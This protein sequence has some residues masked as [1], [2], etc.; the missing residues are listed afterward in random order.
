MATPEELQAAHDLIWQ[1]N[2]DELHKQVEA[3]MVRWEKQLLADIRKH[4]AASFGGWGWYVLPE[5]LP[6][7][8]VESMLKRSVL[9]EGR[10]AWVVGINGEVEDNGAQTGRI[11]QRGQRF[12]DAP[13]APDY[14]V[15]AQEQEQVNA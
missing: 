14:Q 3:N 10:I 8:L 4:Q 12:E 13:L 7:G 6:S 11:I 2:M 1:H 15:E 9:V 5:Y